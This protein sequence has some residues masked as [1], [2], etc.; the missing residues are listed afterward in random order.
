MFDAMRSENIYRPKIDNPQNILDEHGLK[1]FE[2]FKEID[3]TKERYE[4]ILDIKEYLIKFRV[5]CFKYNYSLD[6]DT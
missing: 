3:Q 6:P 1:Y 5:P 4:E 2:S